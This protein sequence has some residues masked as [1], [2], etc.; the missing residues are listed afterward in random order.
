MGT[1]RQKFNLWNDS[2]NLF[3]FLKLFSGI[4][5]IFYYVVS[6]SVC[7]KEWQ[8]GAPNPLSPSFINRDFLLDSPEPSEYHL[9]VTETL[10][11]NN[12]TLLFNNIK[13]FNQSLFPLSDLV[14]PVGLFEQLTVVF[15]SERLVHCMYMF[16]YIFPSGNW[17]NIKIIDQAYAFCKNTL[18]VP[19][20]FRVSPLQMLSSSRPNTVLLKNCI[21]GKF[22]V[23]MFDWQSINLSSV[24]YGC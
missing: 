3:L 18:K 6:G 24:K 5:C 22:W 12:I 19:T 16:I 10:L 23:C 21:L 13:Y 15:P 20:L 8:S 11:T 1:T 17:M 9:L 14:D 4:N 7:R 2:F